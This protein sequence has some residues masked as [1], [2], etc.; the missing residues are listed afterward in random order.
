MTLIAVGLG[1]IL[2]AGIAAAA[3]ASVG[4]WGF[5]LLLA[6]GCATGAIPPLAVLSGAA[7]ADVSR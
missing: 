5:R 6:A 7:V 4:T 3:P 2:L 1:L